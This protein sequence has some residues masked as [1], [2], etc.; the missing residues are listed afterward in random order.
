MSQDQEYTGAPYRRD[1]WHVRA[2]RA[3]QAREGSVSQNE[4]TRKLA[5][6][7]RLSRNETNEKEACEENEEQADPRMIVSQYRIVTEH[8][9]TIRFGVARLFR[10]GSHRA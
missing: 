3:A 9:A 8:L 4:T 6:L 1:M 7:L 10:N 5:S 2:G